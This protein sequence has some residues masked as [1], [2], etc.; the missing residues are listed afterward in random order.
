MNR[1]AGRERRARLQFRCRAE[2]HAVV[3]VQ[4]LGGASPRGGGGVGAEVHV[5][6]LRARCRDRHLQRDEIAGDRGGHGDRPRGGSRTGSGGL[7]GKCR[8]DR[9]GQPRQRGTRTRQVGG[10]G[11]LK[12]EQ[13]LR[14]GRRDR[15]G[16]G[17]EVVDAPLRQVVKGDGGRPV[18][19]SRLDGWCDGIVEAVEGRLHRILGRGRERVVGRCRGRSE[20]RFPEHIHAG[21]ELRGRH[22][23]RGVFKIEVA[24]EGSRA[25]DVGRRRHVEARE[26]MD[27][28]DERGSITPGD[29]AAPEV[30]VGTPR[31]EPVPGHETA[32]QFV[33]RSRVEHRVAQREPAPGAMADQMDRR[34][35]WIGG[36]C[37]RDVGKEIAGRRLEQN[38]RITSERGGDAA[39]GCQS[40][41]DD[42]ELTG[43]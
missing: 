33:D 34:H 16:I 7:R 24:T 35:A 25:R 27:R 30:E 10:R 43:G 12:L 21:N 6:L 19:K 40:R 14:V 3:V 15:R 11:R 36:Q 20:R 32:S 42:D 2:G 26:R 8:V 28:V 9:G 29:I 31:R 37:G 18:G 38:P 41:V 17:E 23:A 5:G 1:K 39:I 13:R 22:V 4:F